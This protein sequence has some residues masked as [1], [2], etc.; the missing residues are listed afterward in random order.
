MLSRAAAEGHRYVAAFDA[1]VGELVLFDGIDLG[2]SWVLDW[3]RDEAGK[4]L[5]FDLDVALW[6]EH[7]AYEFPL[8]GEHTCYKR[9]RL[10]FD[11]VVYVNGLP[12]VQEVNPITGPDGSIDYGNIEGFRS[13]GDGTY[14]FSIELRE[15]RVGAGRIRLEI[16]QFQQPAT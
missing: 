2:D 16:D 9:G 1:E 8:P 12:S 14:D 13:S 15:V 6:P 7:P 3:S 11:E 4:Q 5:I 10:I